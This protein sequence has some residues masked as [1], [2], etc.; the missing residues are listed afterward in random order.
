MRWNLIAP[1]YPPLVLASGR[2][3][4]FF[5]T[6]DGALFDFDLELGYIR[7][8]TTPANSTSGQVDINTLL[9]Y[10]APSTKVVTGPDG[11]VRHAPY[12]LFLN[13]AVPAT[14]SITVKIGLSYTVSVLGTGSLTASGGAS[15]TAS[16]GSDLVVTPTTTTLT[17]TLTGSLTRAHVRQTATQPTYVA[18]GASAAYRL[19]IDY[20]AATL[21]TSTT[22]V[23]IGAGLKSITTTGTID[24]RNAASAWVTATSYAIGDKR[25]NSAGRS[26]VCI[27]AHTSSASDEPGVGSLESLYW[28]RN[29]R[30]VR[31]S[32][33]A[34]LDNY[35]VGTVDSYSG[36]VLVLNVKA[37]G[38]SGTKSSW[39]VIEP[40]GVLIEEARTNLALYSNDL[41]N[42]AWTKT[43][44]TAAL[45]A[46]G[47][48][49]VA[50]SAST[51]TATA[52]NGTVLQAITSASA[53][54]ITSAYV[55]RRTG[56]GTVEMTQDNGTTWAAVTVTAAWARVNI[57]A[58]TLTN[59]T[60]GF[61]IVTSGDAIDVALVD[62]E[63][64]SF[65]TSPIPTGSAQVT[66]AAD[67]VSK[68]LSGM[69]HSAT[70]GTVSFTV[71]PGV[72]SGFVYEID[73]GSTSNRIVGTATAS[74]HLYVDA[75]GV[76][77]VAIDAGTFT[78]NV[79]GRGAQAFKANDFAAVIN[80][81]AVGTDAAGAMPTVTTLR[82][83]YQVLSGNNYINGHL[84]SWRYIK[85]RV[86][87]AEL[88]VLA[89]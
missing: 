79:V 75:G 1:G 54:R 5:G 7:D 69:P 87:D 23:L 42:A 60:V 58:A 3:D 50:N 56:T 82:F 83:G 88:Q 33:Q 37:T 6:D 77:Q 74:N 11:L 84:R 48:D 17:L 89:A 25:Y 30:S 61:R 72:V 53:A 40:K 43:N 46:T 19:P 14:Q 29:E 35:M 49:G 70:E 31:I 73:G 63:V 76:N 10:T 68:L 64:G 59:P 47:P 8:R 66:R 18:A 16:E 67:Q 9:T 13:S 65:I 71:V 21:D 32:D 12:N 38:G 51:L 36:G 41:T 86:T 85:R 78:A 57:A 81:G 52:G 80:G 15:G 45:T 55:K 28:K 22:S 26:Y 20:D 24:Y 34:D 39:H 2:R 44:S 4:A 27:V 62:H